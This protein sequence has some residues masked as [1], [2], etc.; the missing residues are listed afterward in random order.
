MSA[1]TPHEATWAALG[2]PRPRSVRLSPAARA[3]LAHIADLRDVF[4]P[5]DAEGIGGEYSGEPHLA[6][7]LLAARP[8]LAPDTPR[9]A[10]LGAVM[11]G[12]WTGLLALLGE[13]GPWVY[14]P[15]V[16]ALQGLSRAYAALVSAATP[17]RE[18]DVLAAARRHAGGAPSLLARLEATDYRQKGRGAAPET[19]AAL[20]AAF[21]ERAGETAAARRAEWGAR[22]L[23]P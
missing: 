11:A 9:R 15:D 17:A 8:W 1:P 7:D 10:L 20:E 23:R 12:E 6:P 21:W 18:E 19:L 13:Y 3:R 2:Q 16:A 22:R 14:A 5:S 4:Y